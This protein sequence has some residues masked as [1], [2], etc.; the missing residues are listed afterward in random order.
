M[1][2]ANIEEPDF[3]FLDESKPD[4]RN[5]IALLSKQTFKTL[6]IFELNRL[7]IANCVL[8]ISMRPQHP[9]SHTTTSRPQA[10][11]LILVGTAYLDQEPMPSRGRLLI[12]KLD[13]KE[14]KIHLLKDINL[15][16]GIQAVQTLRDNHP[17]LVL[18]QNNRVSL[19]SFG[20][21]HNLDVTLTKLDSKVAGA[22]VQ[23][24]ATV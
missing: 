9:H 17:F 6:D 12:F 2:L 15:Q 10:H 4:K 19:F 21:N 1:V 8:D 13:P 11:K 16:G 24:I 3:G 23:C 14:C 18:G 22:Y 5:L 7:E 20:L